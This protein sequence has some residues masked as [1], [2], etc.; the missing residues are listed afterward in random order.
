MSSL[1]SGELSLG[2][3]GKIQLTG[4]K[5]AKTTIDEDIPTHYFSTHEGHSPSN[6]SDRNHG[7]LTQSRTKKVQE[8][9]NLFLAKINYDIFKN[10]ILPK[11]L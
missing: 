1:T 11:I 6:T 9:V 7:P 5:M 10:V 8:Q 4:K 2:S 3:V